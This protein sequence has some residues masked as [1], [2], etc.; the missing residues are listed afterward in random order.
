MAFDGI[1]SAWDWEYRGMHN[2]HARK[3]FVMHI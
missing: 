2:A 1:D 3:V